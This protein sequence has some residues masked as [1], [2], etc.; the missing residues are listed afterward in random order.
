MVKKILVVSDLH[1]GSNVGLFLPD[2]YDQ[3]NDIQY[4]I[5]DLQTFLFEKWCSMVTT[6]GHVDYV[7]ANGDL[8][9]G[10]N[11]AED[12]EGQ[13]TTDIH[14]QAVV[15]TTLLNMIDTNHYYVSNGSKYHT[16][17]TSGDQIVCDMLEGTWLGDHEFITFDNIM[18]HI[19][20][21]EKY[22]SNPDSRCTAQRKEA[23]IMRAQ[24]TEVDIYLRS[25]T[26]HFNFSG[27]NTD[28]TI[29]T[30]CWK[31]IDHFIGSRSQELPDNGYITITIDGSNYTWDYHVFNIPFSF[32]KKGIRA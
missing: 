13:L 19:R 26:H 15:S 6:V 3:D 20:H 28:I 29:N 5:S 10:P 11:K 9:D 4:Q 18:A 27:T 2:F 32:Y 8:V 21:F 1:C 16:G 7:I 25:H 31:G 30:P 23:R 14:T 24:G 12:G 22:S 17:Q